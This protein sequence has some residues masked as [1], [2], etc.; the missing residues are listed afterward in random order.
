M[1]SDAPLVLPWELLDC[2]F[3]IVDVPVEAARI[4]PY[5]PEGFALDAQASPL[6][7]VTGGGPYLGVEMFT[8][9]DGTAWSSTYTPVVP[10]ESLVVPEHLLFAMW[11]TVH[12]PTLDEL[13]ARGYPVRN[14]TV[15]IAPGAVPASWEG[16]AVVEGLGEIVVRGAFPREGSPFGGEFVEYMEGEDGTLAAWRTD[17]QAETLASGE[18]VVELPGW[19]AEVA[20]GSTVRARGITG[21]WSFT[22]GSVTAPVRP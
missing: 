15:E 10:P 7:P 17:Y 1:A 2:R 5:L 11:D 21:T 20:G 22:D 14:G 18:V 3:L 13:G 12:A 16:I 8:C 6:A 4:E 9:A 19:L